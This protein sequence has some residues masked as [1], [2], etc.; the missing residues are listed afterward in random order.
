MILDLT[1]RQQLDRVVDAG[2]RLDAA[3]EH[4]REVVF[5]ALDDGVPLRRVAE[6]AGVAHATVYRWL[7]EDQAK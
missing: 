6:A 7:G 1:Q 5:E 4:L 2:N 3:K